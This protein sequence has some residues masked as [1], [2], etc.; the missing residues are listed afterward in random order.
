M[1]H[2]RHAPAISTAPQPTGTGPPL[3]DSST[4]P[5]R[6]AAAPVRMRRSTFSRNQIQAIAIVAR[7]S[8]LSS[9][10]AE[11]AAVKKRPSISS[12]GPITPPDR[13]TSISHGTSARRSGA[14]FEAMPRLPRT[15]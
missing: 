13:I 14:S 10:A 6:I 5:A 4:A 3:H 8:R 1:P 7:P 12:T 11:D 2:A 9:S 15:R